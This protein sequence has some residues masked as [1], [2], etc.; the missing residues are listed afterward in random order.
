MHYLL[1][2]EMT[3][4][5]HQD[6]FSMVSALVCMVIHWTRPMVNHDIGYWVVMI[7]QATILHVLSTLR[8]Y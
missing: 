2:R 4:R 1:I 8:R 5:S 6:G 3:G 7:H